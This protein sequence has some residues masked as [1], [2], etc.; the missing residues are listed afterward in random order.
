MWGESGVIR[1]RGGSGIIAERSRGA[2]MRTEN[3]MGGEGGRE[4]EVLMVTPGQKV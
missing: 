1:A 2:Y 4:T 3:V